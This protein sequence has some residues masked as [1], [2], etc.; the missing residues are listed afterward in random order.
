[1]NKIQNLILLGL[2]VL[3]LVKGSYQA[4]RIARFDSVNPR[5]INT[6]RDVIGKST[7]DYCSLTANLT[8]I[9]SSLSPNG[10]KVV[11][12][13]QTTM[14]SKIKQQM[15]DS[16]QKY[17]RD[18]PDTMS[19]LTNDPKTLLAFMNIMNI[20]T[21]LDGSLSF[22]SNSSLQSQCS[23]EFKE[24]FWSFWKNNLTSSQSSAVMSWYN[25]VL[26]ETTTAFPAIFSESV[27]SSASSLSTLSDS[28]KKIIK[29]NI[30]PA[31]Y[32]FFNQGVSSISLMS[33]LSA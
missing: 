6:I 5:S 26:T 21:N 14:E 31:F 33:T 17:I 16:A 7:P 30:S 3:A 13:I 11:K 15:L 24:S 4:G 27:A 29:D 19:S 2:L 12:N 28:D 1:M 9:Y 18:Y 25:Y 23:S 32:T 10:Q 22:Y 8:K 20:Q